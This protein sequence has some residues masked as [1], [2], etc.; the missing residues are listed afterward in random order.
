VN[1][2]ALCFSLRAGRTELEQLRGFVERA[3]AQLGVGQ[4]TATDLLVAVNELM[5][6][7]VVHGYQGGP[8]LIELCVRRVERGVE[9]QLRDQAPPFDPTTLPPPR[10]D[11]PPHLRPP[12]GLGVLLARR[13][14]DELRYRQLPDGNEIVL[15][16]RQAQSS[17]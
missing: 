12:G 9:V 3:L 15:V 11:L 14:S 5:T 1:D 17:A 7:S 6:N 10:I 13:F 2:E 4:P 16:K 8:G